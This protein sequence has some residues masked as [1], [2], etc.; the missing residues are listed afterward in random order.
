MEMQKRL[1]IDA[2]FQLNGILQR[3]A[4]SKIGGTSAGL[5][6]IEYQAKSLSK[7]WARCGSTRWHFK[8]C[9]TDSGKSDITRT[10]TYVTATGGC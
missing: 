7:G 1:N 8:V 6:F 4:L 2:Y 9:H 5:G 3:C 10:W